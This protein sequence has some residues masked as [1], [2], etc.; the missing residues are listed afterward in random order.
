MLTFCI[1]ENNDN[2]EKKTNLGLRLSLLGKVFIYLSVFRGYHKNIY[3]KYIKNILHFFK[4]L[5]KVWNIVKNERNKEK[6]DE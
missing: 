6:K 4:H 2:G 5:R 3:I 1:K